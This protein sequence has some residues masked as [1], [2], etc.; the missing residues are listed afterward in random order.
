MKPSA[1]T[2]LHNDVLEGRWRRSNGAWAQNTER[3]LSLRSLGG[4]SAASY[5]TLCD[6]NTSSTRLQRAVWWYLYFCLCQRNMGS[7][8][9]KP[10]HRFSIKTRVSGFLLGIASYASLPVY[11]CG[12]CNGDD[13]TVCQSLAFTEPPA[14]QRF[15][16]VWISNGL[17]CFSL[18]LHKSQVFSTCYLPKV[19]LFQGSIVSLMEARRH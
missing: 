1:F 7:E 2:V 12:F 3:A 9:G 16:A 18:S 15:K 10:C 17:R 6:W 8:R 11:M 13:S 19:A 4:N 14:T 5:L